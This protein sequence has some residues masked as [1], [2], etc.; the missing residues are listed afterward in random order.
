MPKNTGT[1]VCIGSRGDSTGFLIGRI[2]NVCFFNRQAHPAEMKTIYNARDLPVD[3]RRT[4]RHRPPA[5]DR[6]NPGA[7]YIAT[8]LDD[9]VGKHNALVNKLADKGAL[10]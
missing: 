9:V 2:R 5:T 8:G 10:G 1:P 6:P 7:P 3:G 4:R